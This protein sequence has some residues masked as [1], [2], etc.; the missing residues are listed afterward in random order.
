MYNITQLSRKAF[1]SPQES[2]MHKGRDKFPNLDD[3][4]AV[5]IESYINNLHP[6]TYAAFYPIIANVFS[7]FIPLLEQ[8]LTDLVHSRRQMK[9]CKKADIS[10]A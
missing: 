2:L 3:D 6:I 1:T 4:G 9:E 8:V 5:T 7:K 10:R